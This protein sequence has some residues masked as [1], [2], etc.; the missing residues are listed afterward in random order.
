LW[1]SSKLTLYKNAFVHGLMVH[2]KKNSLCTWKKK[3]FF[4]FFFSSTTSQSWNKPT[5]YHTTSTP[6]SSM[7]NLPHCI[8]W[9]HVQLI[10]WHSSLKSTHIMTMFECNPITSII[11]QPLPPHVCNIGRGIHASIVWFLILKG[12]FWSWF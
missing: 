9:T 12:T 1:R 11:L 7:P 5:K 6:N 4:S 8:P 2:C 10:S 3:S